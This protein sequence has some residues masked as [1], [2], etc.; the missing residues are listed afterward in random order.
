MADLE[1][2]HRSIDITKKAIDDLTR[3]ND[4]LAGNTLKTTDETA[5]HVDYRDRCIH[6]AAHLQQLCV[7]G[8]QQIKAK[9]TEI[10]EYKKKVIQADTKLKHKQNLYEAV[11][12]D[13]NLHAKPLIESQSEIAEMK[14]KLKIMNYQNQR[15]NF[16]RSQL[17]DVLISECDNLSSQLIRQNEELG[18]A[19]SKIKTQ[20]PLIRSE[21]YNMDQRKALRSKIRSIRSQDETLAQEISVLHSNKKLIRKLTS[22]ITWKRTRIKALEDELENL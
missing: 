10:F 4:I 19:Y 22:E 18:K 2:T 8:M 12:S 17:A 21:I 11:Q 6:E 14:Q 1:K 7:D 16:L 20:Q 9:E 3:E 15:M 13:R 5:K